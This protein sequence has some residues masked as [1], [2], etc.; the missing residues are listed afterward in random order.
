MRQRVA[1]GR[2]LLSRKD[3]L[4]LDE[5]LGALDAQTREHMQEWLLEIWSQFRK[6][7]ALITH[8]VD[9]AVFLADR[10]YVLTAQP[11]RVKTEVPVGLPRPRTARTRVSAEYVQVRAEVYELVREEEQEP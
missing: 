5:P 3:L 10:I 7:V 6:T 11:G 8:D 4:L 1:F 9:E 2:T